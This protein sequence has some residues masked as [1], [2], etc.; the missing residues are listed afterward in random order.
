MRPFVDFLELFDAH[1]G[2]NLRGFELSMPKQLLDETDVGASFEHVRGAGVAEEVA[3]ATTPQLGR[4]DV[5]GHHAAE[6]VRVKGLAVA[7]KEKSVLGSMDIQLRS[8][9]IEVFF[10]PG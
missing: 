1:F 2:V 10:Q 6:D 4:F 3:T 8:Y 9:G 7:A 5:F